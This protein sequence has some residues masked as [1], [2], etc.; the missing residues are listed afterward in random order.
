MP[1]G[2]K[3]SF[4]L[5]KLAQKG[6]QHNLDRNRTYCISVNCICRNPDEALDGL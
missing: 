1:K 2:K 3:N 6:P 5:H 4:R